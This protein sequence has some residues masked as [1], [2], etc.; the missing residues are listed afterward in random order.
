MAESP[1]VAARCRTIC[2][3]VIDGDAVQDVVFGP[4]GLAQAPRVPRADRRLLHGAAGANAGA[5]LQ[6]ARTRHSLD[7]RAGFKRSVGAAAST[8]TIM[9]GGADDDIAAVEQLRSGGGQPPHPR[10]RG[11]AAAGKMK[12]VSQALVGST[13]V[14]LAESTDTRAPRPSCRWTGYLPAWRALGRFDR[15]AKALAADGGGE[16]RT[17]F[18]PRRAAAQGP[19][20]GETP[21]A[22]PAASSFRC[23]RPPSASTAPMSRSTARAT[24]KRS[25]SRAFTRTA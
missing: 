10:R 17:A 22:P 7:R 18:R 9:I 21:R 3:C 24:R 1:A 12:V 20:R 19:A 4:G 23:C 8:L 2:L 15:A 6:A 14:L 11:E 5:G 13:A 25:R 16:F